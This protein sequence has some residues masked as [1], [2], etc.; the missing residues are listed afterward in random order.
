MV[1]SVYYTWENR[2]SLTS[3]FIS[4]RATYMYHYCHTSCHCETHASL[5]LCY[6]SF[7]SR[8]HVFD[9]RVTTS[10]AVEWV[11]EWLW[12]NTSS[13]IFQPYRGEHTTRILKFTFFTSDL[14]LTGSVF[15]SI[16]TKNW[17]I[18]HI[19]N[20]HMYA[21]PIHHHVIKYYERCQF[22]IHNHIAVLN[23]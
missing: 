11:N 10:K 21:C 3:A 18:L 8:C 1:I 13:P 15:V 17:H 9:G 12:L 4:Q 5:Y 14:S 6:I 16:L 2:I 19:L 22:W 23:L 20:A 7:I